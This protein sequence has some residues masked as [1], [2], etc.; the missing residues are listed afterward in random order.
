MT[1]KMTEYEF[2]LLDGSKRYEFVSELGDAFAFQRMYKAR[3]FKPVDAP[4]LWD[5]AARAAGWEQRDSHF[6]RCGVSIAYVDWKT[7]CIAEGISP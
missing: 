5:T 3:S 6:T 1:D 4:D 2:T 7:L